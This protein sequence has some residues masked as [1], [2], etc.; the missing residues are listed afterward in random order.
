MISIYLS[1]VTHHLNPDPDVEIN[2]LHFPNTKI[3]QTWLLCG[4]SPKS[5][6]HLV[7]EF[8]VDTQPHQTWGH[9]PLRLNN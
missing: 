5:M 8:G 7:S 9:G 1:S 6:Q 2:M 4:C 3:I